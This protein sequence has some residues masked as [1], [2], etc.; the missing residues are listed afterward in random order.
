MPRT[1]RRRKAHVIPTRNSPADVLTPPDGYLTTWN[2][3]S[4]DG[5]FLRI[6]LEGP[7]K[8]MTPSDIKQHYLNEFS[9]YAT[10]TLSS[11]VQNMK[12]SMGRD[13]KARVAQG[14]Q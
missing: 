14:Q 9:K 10:K 8:K 2:S 3:A 12:K 13:V 6:V 7:G 11:A 1:P 4:D 5:A